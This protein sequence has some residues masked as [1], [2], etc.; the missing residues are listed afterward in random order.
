MYGYMKKERI[1]YWILILVLAGAFAYFFFQESFDDEKY[2]AQIEQLQ[3][4]ADS[5]AIENN[6][7]ESQ[8]GQLET[9]ISGL[10]GRL[11][12]NQSKIDSLKQN[13]QERIADV[14]NLGHSDLLRFF[15]ERYGN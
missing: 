10:Q 5:L 8:I 4:E 6:G 14:N 2:Q 9:R 7:F 1:I 3:R 13:A 12:D 15:T 11:E